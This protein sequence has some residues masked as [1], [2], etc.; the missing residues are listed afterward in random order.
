MWL[1]SRLYQTGIFKSTHAGVPTVVIGNVVAGG[2]G[3][4]PLVVA[5]VKHLQQQGIDAGVVSRGYGRTCSATLEV[6]ESTPVSE[7]GDEPAL[8][9]KASGAP[10]FVAAQ[11][12]DAA[13]A[14]LSAYPGTQV[15]VCDDGLQHHA[16]QRDLE[17]VVF[18]DRGVGNGWMLPAGPLRE[19]WP[20]RLTEIDLL[21]HTGAQPAFAGFTSTRMLNS[22]AFAADGT[23]VA[24]A[25]LRN[26]HIVAMAAIANPE[27]FFSMLKACGLNLSREISLPDHD[28][29]SAFD[30]NAYRGQT[31]LCTEKDAIKLFRFSV[32]TSVTLLAVPLVFAPEPAFF[33]AF[34]KLLSPLLTP[35][36]S[37]LP[38]VDGHKI[39]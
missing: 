32:D 28:S 27:A 34:D 4:T 18:D 16:L 30:I 1:R 29:F 3:K 24:L 37:Q 39:A 10:V 33:A 15:L 36:L 17:I 20:A 14:L 31:V 35:V 25:D 11:R 12:I 5:L 6:F 22:H 9:K 21:L 19:S 8:I 23:S 13:L 38:S 7:S 26:Q 2:A